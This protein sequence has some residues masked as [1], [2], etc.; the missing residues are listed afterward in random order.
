[1]RSSDM[2]KYTGNRIASPRRLIK[3]T[4]ENYNPLELEKKKK[5]KKLTNALHFGRNKKR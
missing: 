2:L 4:L 5:T 3:K 1:M